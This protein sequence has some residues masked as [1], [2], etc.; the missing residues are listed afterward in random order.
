MLPDLYGKQKWTDKYIR[1]PPVVL[2]IQVHIVIY[3]TIPVI[4][5][6]RLG[7]PY[8][9][10]ESSG[11]WKKKYLS[12]RQP[13]DRTLSRQMGLVTMFNCAWINLEKTSWKINI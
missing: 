5:L 6:Q 8:I 9:E 4:F 13:G 3:E 2:R 12:L 10:Q 11:K 1:V 7:K